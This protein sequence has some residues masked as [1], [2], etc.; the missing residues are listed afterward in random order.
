[1]E[2]FIVSDLITLKLEGSQTVIYVNG[3]RF[4]QCKRIVLDINL[5]EVKSYEDVDSIDEA[6]EMYA[7]LHEGDS[8]DGGHHQSIEPEQEFW[9]HS[10]NI[11]AWVENNYDTRLLHR[12]LAFPLLK[13]LANLGD[14][15]A[16]HVF[17]SEIV[18]RM[19]SGFA[20]T[21]YY[22]LLKGYVEYLQR[23]D[24]EEL[25][26]HF[27]T[28]GFDIEFLTEL[29][30]HGYFHKIPPEYL[31]YNAEKIFNVLLSDAFIDDC[32]ELYTLPEKWLEL[33]NL[34]AEKTGLCP[35]NE[36]IVRHAYDRFLNKHSLHIFVRLVEL[37]NISPRQEKIQHAYILLATSD[38]LD[39]YN[40]YSKVLARAT[41]NPPTEATLREIYHADKYWKP[42]NGYY[43]NRLHN[44][45]D[46]A[47]TEIRY[48]KLK[49]ALKHAIANDEVQEEHA[50]SLLEALFLGWDSHLSHAKTFLEVVVDAG[51][52]SFLKQIKDLIYR[53]LVKK[54]AWHKLDYFQR[55]T[56]AFDKKSL[57]NRMKEDGIEFYTLN[58][59]EDDM[60]VN[61]RCPACSKMLIH[62][63][64]SI[65]SN[66]GVLIEVE[67]PKSCE[68][69]A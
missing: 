40:E 33:V 52:K 27:Y 69:H 66:C 23:D 8:K 11:Q 35:Q 18:M 4:D 10:S 19:K 57:L 29:I 54:K 45:F 6:T 43:S 2:E 36:K 30:K 14:P 47:F 24:I 34:M 68:Q 63:P 25:L 32:I 12:N 15:D 9:G 67:A 21:I 58:F 41:G 55:K 20:P 60:P 44:F 7:A 56:K 42:K 51:E 39:V 65:C 49:K 62:E 3:E 37:C 17:R 13:K 64:P 38:F 50:E 59:H 5:N 22:L 28:I 53:T 31:A 61:Y 46:K 26:I 1:M 16:K 48:Q